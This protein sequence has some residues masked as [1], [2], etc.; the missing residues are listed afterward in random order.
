MTDQRCVFVQIPSY[1][2]PQLIPTLID[3]AANASVPTAIR[4]VV[5]WQHGPDED[6]GAFEASGIKLDSTGSINGRVVHSLHLGGVV[7]ELIDVPFREAKGAGW[8][9][10]VAQQRYQGEKYNLQIDAHHRFAKAWDIEMI[11]ML[12]SLKSVSS[13][14]LLTGHPP[15]FWP[16]TYPE[17]RQ[18]LPAVMLVDEFSAFGVVRF[19]AKVVAPRLSAGRPWRARFM[20]G[21]FVFSPGSFISEVPQD[22]NHYFATE[23]VVMTVRAYTHG[24]DMFHPHLPLLWHYYGSQS[25]KVWDDGPVASSA[26]GSFDVPISDRASTSARRARSLLGMTDELP[27]G[28]GHGF[29]LGVERTLRQYERY[30]GLS[31]PLRGVHNSATGMAEPN[32][33]HQSVPSAEWEKELICKRSLRVVISYRP[34]ESIEIHS[35]QVAMVTER[36]EA[37]VVHQ[38]S[39]QDIITLIEASSLEVLYE[40]SSGPQD[41]PVAFLVEAVTSHPDAQQFFSVAAQEIVE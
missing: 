8:A 1:R 40:H 18:E 2:D 33:L 19:R 10:S 37:T 16:E 41:L 38:L 35:A 36:G 3:L 20:S 4:V 39:P 7:I 15:A 24:Y 12:E 6:L 25:P 13:K 29:G 22:P 11:T 27:E 17:G 34:L 32:D 5:C 23:E 14:P 26:R 31:F 9:R 30:A 21:G 28:G